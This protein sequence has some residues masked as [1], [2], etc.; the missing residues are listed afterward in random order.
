MSLIITS[1]SQGLDETNQIG[2]AKPEQ[3][4]NHMKNS[5]IIEPDSEIAVESVK[6]NRLP[7]LDAGAAIV[8][9]FWFGE[10]LG[11]SPIDPWASGPLEESLSYIIPTQNL[12]GR[13]VTPVD[14][15]DIYVKTL[16][17]AYSLHPEIKST[18]IEMTTK[19]SAGGVFEGYDY[20]IPQVGAAA[21]NAVPSA[22]SYIATIPSATTAF[23]EGAYVTWDGSD[24]SGQE[25]QFGQL[26]PRGSQSGPICLNAG[27]I[28]YDP[29]GLDNFTIGLSRPYCPK[30]EKTSP[31]TAESGGPDAC[32]TPEE[33]FK[34]DGGAFGCGAYE[35]DYYDYCAEV[36]TDGK[37]RLYHAL[38][39]AT[40]DSDA[41]Y[42]LDPGSGMRM[43]EIKYYEKNNTA[44][45]AANTPNSSFATGV[46]ITWSGS[47]GV[48]TFETSG[49]KVTISVSGNRIASP[50]T[51]NAS[52][53]GQIPKP[54]AQTC[55]KMYPT[56]SIWEDDDPIPI[57]KYTGR[58]SATMWNNQ[59]ENSWITKT[60]MRTFLNENTGLS[61]S[62]PIFFENPNA[63]ERPPW[64]NALDWGLSVD[65]R[66]MF[67]PYAATNAAPAVPE[68]GGLVHTYRGIAI[69][70]LVDTYENIFIT[71]RAERY[72][73]KAIQQW[74]P[75][76]GFILG[77]YPMGFSPIA[78]MVSA[79]LPVY[80]G[81]SFASAQRPSLMSQHSSFIR[82]PTFTH[83]T[84][85]FGTGNPSKI[86]F[87]VPRFD[88]AGTET[89]ALYYQNNDKTYVDLGNAQ[90]LNITELD[91]HIVRKNETFVEDL[92]GSTEIVFHVRAKK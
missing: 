32:Q 61:P 76:S 51:V 12:I 1:S 21:A 20:K 22:T 47:A 69:T 23:Q 48:I 16:K 86:L 89:G 72:M 67:L 75:N 2:I 88:N 83:Q 8:G 91:V 13:S 78:N 71:G 10:R 52:T 87:Q 59:P 35:R 43:T 66:D 37:L 50:I 29:S 54:I 77:F 14:F 9:N 31:V 74:Q 80:K 56:F 4:K 81:A 49:E 24:L 18:D 58:T 45:T 34:P 63:Q 60:L 44:F 41:P 11:A 46:P 65:S 6:I 79:G 53:K 38:P 92:T 5:L 36:A 64:N 33:V 3:Y 85:N 40:S 73:G 15:A 30:V 25:G 7:M 68:E 90:Q 39:A 62:Q 42:A 55:W 27:L 84:Y 82:V 19:Y 26:Q 57:D 17:E 28:Q 70:G